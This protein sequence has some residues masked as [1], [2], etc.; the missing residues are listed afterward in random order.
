MSYLEAANK[1]LKIYSC[2][3]R[4]R[5]SYNNDYEYNNNSN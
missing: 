1:A 2:K 5:M 3:A 4:K